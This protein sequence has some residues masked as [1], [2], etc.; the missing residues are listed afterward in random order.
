[1]KAELRR[2]IVGEDCRNPLSDLALADA[3]RRQGLPIA[4]RTVAKY[5]DES[6]I[7]PRHHRKTA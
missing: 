1:V 7:A 3:L 6:A 4:R 5:R 2:L